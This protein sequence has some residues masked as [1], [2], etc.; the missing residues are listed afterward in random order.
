MTAPNQANPKSIIGKCAVQAVGVSAT[1]IV[2]NAAASNTLVKVN[3]LY[4]GN[5]DTTT[6]YKI[7]VELYRPSLSP[8]ATSYR[9]AYQVIIPPNAGLDVISKYINLEEGD[10]LRLTAD[11]A[12]KLE[13]VASYEVIS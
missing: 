6:S 5:V 10:S 2:S 8:A 3:A 4:V 11:T 13:A 1:A 9:M 7:T 12:A